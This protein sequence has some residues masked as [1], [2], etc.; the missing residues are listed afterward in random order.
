MPSPNVNVRS[1]PVSFDLD[2]RSS[3]ETLAEIEAQLVAAGITYTKRIEHGF[4]LDDGTLWKIIFRVDVADGDAAKAIIDSTW[5][6]KGALVPEP[7][8]DPVL[9]T[10]LKNPGGFGATA[11]AIEYTSGVQEHIINI[12]VADPNLIPSIFADAIGSLRGGAWGGT[13]PNVSTDTAGNKFQW[14]KNNPSPSVLTA[15]L[16]QI[17]MRNQGGG[18]L[19]SLTLPDDDFVIT[20]VLDVTYPLAAVAAAPFTIPAPSTGDIRRKLMWLAED[21]NLYDGYDFTDG[22]SGLT[23]H[24]GP[25]NFAQAVARDPL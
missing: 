21:G 22:V 10:S 3:A 15:T 11:T 17:F 9:I 16:V 8:P 6:V 2:V 14:V 18:G 4:M 13:G 7:A 19:A 12:H 25:W 5:G 20:D 24:A 23:V 1:I